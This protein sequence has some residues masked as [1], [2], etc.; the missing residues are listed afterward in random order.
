M[1]IIEGD[2]T[3]VLPTLE[4]GSVDAIITDPPYH[5][6]SGKNKSG[7]F[8]GKAWDG[9]NIAF[10]P[11][12]WRETLRVAK[13]GAC[14]TAF[15]GTRTHHRLMCAIEDAGWEL[16]DCLMWLHGE[17]FPKHR[18][19]LKP[20]WEPI[21]L[22][23]KSG[24][25]WLNI[26]G[27]RIEG[28]VLATTCCNLFDRMDDDGW[29]ESETA[30]TPQADGR[31]PANVAHDGSDEVMDTFA[32]FGK[33]KSKRS[34]RGEVKIW[35]DASRGR[36]GWTGSSSQRGHDDSGLVSRF[37][38]C[39]KASKSDRGSSNGHLTVKP[40]SLMRWLCRLVTPPGGLTL[41]PFLGSGTT[42]IAAHAEGRDCIGIERVPEYVAIARQRLQAAQAEF[43]L[44]P[45]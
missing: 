17:G 12:V 44:F 32:A 25:K 26:D 33:S 11:E 21:I 2:S 15:G 16:V 8:M 14:L 36:Q 20:A 4:S 13:P 28:K 3:E 39:A 18:S 41:D 1:R 42:M 27:C 45:E 5:L 29:Q 37:F 35:S 30:F 24:P 38:Y 7:G 23:R 34:M 19:H 22:A 10:R 9:G 40:M 31:W 6:K 43:P